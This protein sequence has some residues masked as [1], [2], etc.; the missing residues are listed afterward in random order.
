MLKKT[1]IL[2]LALLLALSVFAVGCGGS[3]SEADKEEP[4]ATEDTSL[5]DVQ[6]KGTLILGCDDKFAPMG[7]V[8]E[9][10]NLTGFDI[11][12]AE[13]V[14]EKLGVE[15]EPKPIDWK[16]KELELQNK[17]I[18]VIWNGYSID[19]D[20]NKKVEFT[21]PYLQNEQLIAVR[22]DSDIK[23]KADLKDKVLGVQT[24][25]AA[26]TVVNE[27]TEFVDSLKE[28]RQ[29]DDYQ[30]AMMDLKGGSRI[31]GVAG[32]K[33]LLN[34]TMTKQPDTYAL[35]EDSLTD[36]YFG[37]GCRQGEVALREAIDKALDE[38][39]EDGTIE[40]ISNKWFNENIVIRDVE[41]LTQEE[42][43]AK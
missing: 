22:A 4:A 24:D 15:L 25:S 19:A 11:E 27:D 26:E 10:G 14:C 21:K 3:D 6:E 2:M 5:K 12:L 31:D 32:D 7:F 39:Y 43:E 37:I 8:D 9:D 36:E 17:K 35:L 20:R 28:L 41:K 38:L 18:D 13:A 1:S 34:Y 23:T 16:S 29:Y 40:K 33:I 30:N 42:L